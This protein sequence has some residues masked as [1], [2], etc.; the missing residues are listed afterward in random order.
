M[1]DTGIGQADA[2]KFGSLC[3]IGGLLQRLDKVTGTDLLTSRFFT[4]QLGHMNMKKQPVCAIASRKAY[5][6]GR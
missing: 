6:S 4:D 2:Q 3:P 5:T 1:L